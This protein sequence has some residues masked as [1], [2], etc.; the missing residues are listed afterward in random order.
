MAEQILRLKARHGG[1]ASHTRRNYVARTTSAVTETKWERQPNQAYTPLM[2]DVL[3]AFGSGEESPGEEDTW[4][5]AGR[6]GG[7]TTSASRGILRPGVEGRV[8]RNIA[9]LV[10]GGSTSEAEPRED[11]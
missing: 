3:A 5:R 1:E 4:A 11:E 7:I 6:E 2:A 10:R 8:R 9:G